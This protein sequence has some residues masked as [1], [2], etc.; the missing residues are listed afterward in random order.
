MLSRLGK[1]WGVAVVVLLF[2]P[3]LACAAPGAKSSKGT[4][5]AGQAFTRLADQYFDAFHLSTNPSVAT[6]YGIHKY[7]DKLE[8]YS[9][10]GIDAE[11][12]ALKSWEGRVAAVDP[13]SL[14]VRRE[15]L[16]DD[17]PVL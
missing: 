3:L 2:A 10:A 8:D 15:M 12:G 6:S 16:H 5:A 11:V 1:R 17:S 14:G 4:T 7:A 13:D 9:R